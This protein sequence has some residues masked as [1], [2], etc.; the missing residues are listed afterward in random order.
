[1]QLYRLVI[2]DNSNKDSAS[3]F[4]VILDYLK[5]QGARSS[6]IPEINYKSTNSLFFM[7]LSFLK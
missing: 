2:T 1:M 5:M 4:G 6:K 7:N 3:L